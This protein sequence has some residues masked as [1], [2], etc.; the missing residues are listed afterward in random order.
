MVGQLLHQRAQF[1]PRSAMVNWMDYLSNQVLSLSVLEK[2]VAAAVGILAIHA[3][4]RVLEKTLPQRFGRTDARYRVR[5][6]LG[7]A[8]YVAILVFVAILFEDR[9][10]RLS[11]T[12]GVVGAG[13]AV[14]LQDLLASMAGAF[15]ISFSRL[16]AVGDR[17]QVGETRGDV[18]DIGLLRTTLMETGNWVSRDIYNGRIVHIPNST[19][20][21]GTIFNCSQGF[22]FIWDEIKVVFTTTSDCQLAREM[23]LRVAREAIGEYVA[24]AQLSWKTITDNYRSANPSLEPTVSLV[25]NAGSFEFT[26]DYVVDYTQHTVMRDR[27]F[28][29][30]AEEVTNSNGR[31]EWASSGVTIVNQPP[32]P[33]SV[34][35]AGVRLMSEFVKS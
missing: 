31:L 6:F 32:T 26:V 23:L 11:F 12:L 15:A 9:L 13:V 14:A 34:V 7:F 8:G 28:T 1:A 18:I 33:G 29:K 10:G 27:L 4:F 25:V 35:M 21:K 20:L 2:C 22:R 24:E 30:I 16:F 19:V 5:K 17:I 3:A